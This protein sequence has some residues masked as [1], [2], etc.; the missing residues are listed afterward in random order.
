LVSPALPLGCSAADGC[1]SYPL[2]I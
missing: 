2:Y 1:H